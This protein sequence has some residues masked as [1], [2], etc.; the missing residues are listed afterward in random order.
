LASIK[1]FQEIMHLCLFSLLCVF[2]H[3]LIFSR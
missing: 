3:I 1:K 2:R